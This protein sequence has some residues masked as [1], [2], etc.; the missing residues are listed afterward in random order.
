MDIIHTLSVEIASY[1][2]T[3]E[4]LVCYHALARLRTP[5]I[6]S[7][8]ITDLARIA[9]TVSD[10]ILPKIQPTILLAQQPKEL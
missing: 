10:L 5:I 8:I 3:C 1:L 6:A 2:H 7:L 4:T 9:C